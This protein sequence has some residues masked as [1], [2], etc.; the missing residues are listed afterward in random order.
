M[1][2]CLALDAGY[3]ILPEK[4][5]YLVLFDHETLSGKPSVSLDS[6]LW[7]SRCHL[8][9]ST[10][11]WLGVT[12]PSLLSSLFF[13]KADLSPQHLDVQSHVRNHVCISNNSSMLSLKHLGGT[14]HYSSPSHYEPPCPIITIQA[15]LWYVVSVCILGNTFCGLLCL[16]SHRKPICPGLLSLGPC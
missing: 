4:G 10:L 15:A 7:A 3:L 5:L 11:L 1:A 16:L 8:F 13:G 9:H 6:L 14:P 12:C 2:L